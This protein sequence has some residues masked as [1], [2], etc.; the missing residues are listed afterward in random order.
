MSLKATELLCDNSLR[1][2]NKQNMTALRITGF[3]SLLKAVFYGFGYLRELFQPYVNAFFAILA[4]V[5]WRFGA[6]VG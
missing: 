4:K 5:R 3:L 6:F 1:N 2:F